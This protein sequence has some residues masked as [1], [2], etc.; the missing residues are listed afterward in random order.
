MGFTQAPDFFRIPERAGKY[1]NVIVEHNRTLFYSRIPMVCMDPKTAVL[2]YQ[3]AERAKSELIISSQ[4]I[5][6]LTGFSETE[7]AG[8]KRM[9]LL[10]LESVRS[11]LQFA[12]RSTGQGEFQKAI[13]SISEAISL[14]ES[15]QPE[16]ASQ[17]IAAAISASTT[18]AQNAWQI[19]SEHGLL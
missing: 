18:P 6:A 4:L 8:G 17:K 11:E 3:F 1:Y 2:S 13:T 15:N 19:L 14:V 5:I 12:L 10:L 16:Q 7:R 9:L